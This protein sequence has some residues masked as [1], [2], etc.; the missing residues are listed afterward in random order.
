MKINFLKTISAAVV[1]LG[2]ASSAMALPYING[3]LTIFGGADMDTNSVVTAT[4]VTSWNGGIFGPNPLVLTADGDFSALAGSAV[5]FSAPWDFGPVNGLYTVGG[6]TFDL[7]SATKDLEL[8]GN[9]QYSL[10]V[11]GTGIM[12]AAGYVTSSGTFIFT[13]QD[14]PANGIFSF[15]ASSTVVPDGGITALLLGLGLTGVAMFSRLTR[16]HS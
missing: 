15:S 11:A 8:E 14:Q 13:T 12:S 9:G 10:T 2:L 3:T 5:T 4:Q 6:F 1:A 7:L 16:K